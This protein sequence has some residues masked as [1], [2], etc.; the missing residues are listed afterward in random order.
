M[1]RCPSCE[2]PLPE[3][4]ER[5]GARC[6]SCRD[7]LYEP[8]GRFARA[9]RAGEAT[10]AAHPTN[11]SIGPCGR[12]GNYL[13]EVCRT[14]WRDQLLCAACAERAL[15]SNEATPEQV[16]AVFR[17]ALWSLLLGIGAWVLALLTVLAIVLLA[18]SQSLLLL[19]LLFL[20]GVVSA[21]APAV[22][23]IGLAVSVL[24]GRGSHMIMAT[25]ALMLSGL[26]VGF[27]IGYFVL[28]VW[29]V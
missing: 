27:L 8:P 20:V 10:C 4:R 21:A 15:G 5:I 1:A 12:C 17:Q 3:N 19:G 18:S 14:R 11:E 6:P 29:Q 26:Y 7:P 25:I 16:R 28:S 9:A 22:F 13:C 2:Y 23:S 24:R